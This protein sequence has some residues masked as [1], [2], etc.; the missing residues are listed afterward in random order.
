MSQPFFDVSVP[1]EGDDTQA[2]SLHGVNLSELTQDQL[3]AL[4]VDVSAALPHQDLR[5]VS[6]EQELTRQLRAAQAL[7]N[8]TILDKHTPANQ[9]AQTVNAV[10]SVLASLGKLQSDIYTSE[11]LKNIELALIKALKTLP[12]SAQHE[13]FVNYER[14][15][16][17]HH[18]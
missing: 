11:R 10:S 16:G 5:D 8:A 17:E 13:F 7:Q 2:E 12:E 15:L 6:I 3:Y 18:G 4:Y 14:V 1:Q 9:K